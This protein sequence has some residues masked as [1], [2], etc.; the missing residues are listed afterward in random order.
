[1]VGK[2]AGSVYEPGERSGAWI[3]RR[4][5]REQE[6]VIGG[7]RAGRA[8]LRFADR[9][10][11]RKE[12]ADLRGEGEETA[13]SRAFATRFFRS[14]RS[15]DIDDCPFTNLPEKK[16]SRWGEA[17]TAE[18]M[19][20]CRWVKPELVCQVAFVEWTEAAISGTA[21]SSPCATTFAPRVLSANRESRWERRSLS[22]ARHACAQPESAS[23]VRH[24]RAYKWGAGEACW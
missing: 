19:K 15:C 24:C 20:E 22:A 6:F 13:S 2:R 21:P 8:W 1:M 11:L 4:T 3:K 18:K 5:N 7:Y 17:L 12:A 23:L 10:R 14:S 16:A 9:R